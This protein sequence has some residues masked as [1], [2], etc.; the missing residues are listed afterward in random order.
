MTAGRAVAALLVMLN[1]GCATSAPDRTG[2]IA[3]EIDVRGAGNFAVLYRLDTDGTLSWGGGDGARAGEVTWRG[4]MSDAEIDGLL[5]ILVSD[6]WFESDPA[7]DASGD[8]PQRRTT[9]RLDGPKGKR[10]LTL[11]GSSRAV[12]RVT[13]YLDPISRRRYDDFLET[14]PKPGKEP[15]APKASGG[16]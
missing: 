10:R 15:P 11:A 8:V 6:G 9:I 13:A 14:L 5:M 1:A 7:P 12:D 4:T 2:G 3:I 16:V